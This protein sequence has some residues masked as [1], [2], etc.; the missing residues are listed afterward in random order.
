MHVE[1][2]GAIYIDVTG[3]ITSDTSQ[4]REEK[5]EIFVEQKFATVEP[6]ALLN[7]FSQQLTATGNG[8]DSVQI[9]LQSV[10]VA[11]LYSLDL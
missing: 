10:L 7:S 4:S 8:N 9:I 2:E 11:M 6:I 3:P 5:V 1:F